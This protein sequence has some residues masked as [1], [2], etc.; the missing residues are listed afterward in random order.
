MTKT[1]TLIVAAVVLGSVSG[2]WAQGEVPMGSGR[3]SA[4]ETCT[5]QAQQQVPDQAA[6]KKRELA[7]RA[8][9]KQLGRRP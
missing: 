3:Y 4:I 9:M 2:A 1:T 8:C 5:F 7:Y 6:M